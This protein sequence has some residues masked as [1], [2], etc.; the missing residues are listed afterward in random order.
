M[1]TKKALAATKPESKVVRL[2][3]EA[4]AIV[5]AHCHGH[6]E[7]A[8]MVASVFIVV[9]NA[10]LCDAGVSLASRFEQSRPGKEADIVRLLLSEPAKP[11]KRASGQ[12]RAKTVAKKGGRHA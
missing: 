7:K 10:E 4:S 8:G 11:A 2:T 12:R 6:P 9:G 5:A 1:K 3:R